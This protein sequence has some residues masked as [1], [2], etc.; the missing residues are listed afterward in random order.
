MLSKTPASL[1]ALADDLGLSDNAV[2]ENISLLK[3]RGLRVKLFDTPHG[4]FVVIEPE[5]WRK[6]VT[7]AEAYSSAR[8]GEEP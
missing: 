3:I 8:A 4:P 1:R 2:R 7:L 6:A 5:G